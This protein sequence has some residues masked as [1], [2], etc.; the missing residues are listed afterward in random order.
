MR[1]SLSL[2]S[3]LMLAVASFSASLPTE[4]VEAKKL[5]IVVSSEGRAK[6]VRPGFEMDELS[7]AYLIFRK[8]GFSIDIASP[9]GGKVEAGNYD[10]K[11]PFNADFASNA[12]AAKT[13]QNTQRTDAVNSKNYAA[14]YIVGG[15]GAMF[16]LPRDQ[17]LSKLIRDVYEQGGIVGAVCHGP[18]ALVNVNLSNGQ[19]LLKDKNVTGFTNEE[20]VV[21]GKKWKKEYPFLLE[22]A[23][24]G[25]GARWKE[26]P[27]MMS[28]VV[29]DGRLVTGQNPYST[30]G[31]AEAMIRAVGQ[32]PVQRMAWRD[33]LTMQLME[34]ALSFGKTDSIA[35]ELNADPKKYHIELIGLVGY[36]QLE[37]ADTDSELRTALLL[38]ELAH[39]HMK[40]PQ[41]KLG[42]AVANQK[43]GNIPRARDLVKAV[44][45]QHPDMAEAKT[46]WQTLPQ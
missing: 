22:D 15:K 9:A 7:Q 43:L 5:L 6:G 20:E 19:S 34:N 24:I 42:M 35:Q 21:F 18:A 27:L 38:M 4:A 25:K 39:P 44:L 40:E 31:V 30:P 13:L 12:L 3:I 23:I 33:E 41:L 8:N 37:V 14:V 11:E 17:A 1:C 2:S 29:T 32:A 46:L 28:N 26:A 45:D 36:Y 10:A 16:D